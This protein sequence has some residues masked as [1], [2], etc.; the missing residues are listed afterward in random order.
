MPKNRPGRIHYTTATAVHVHGDPVRYDGF[1]GVAIKQ[2]AVPH[3][4]AA[5]TVQK[6]IQIGENF[7]MIVKG[8]VEVPTVSG[9]T[10]GA[11]VYISAANALSTT[12]GGNSAFGR[13]AEVAG[14]RGLAS[15]FQRID[16][17]TKL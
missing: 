8:I 10:K 7:A 12:S 16:L 1:S 15:G 14:E 5:G 17:D 13:V 2:K 6:Q 9:A 4:S 3:T 11:L